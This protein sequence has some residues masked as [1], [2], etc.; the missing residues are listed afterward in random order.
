MA[1][2]FNLRTLATNFG[3]PIG[4]RA[5][6][7]GAEKAAE[8]REEY[9]T[10]NKRNNIPIQVIEDVD[11]YDKLSLFGTPLYST[12]FI[13]KPVYSDYE[14]NE[15]SQEYVKKDV[16]LLHNQESGG[17]QGCFIESVLI[18]VSQQR[19]IVKTIIN[20]R[21]GSVKEFINNGDYSL[22][23]QGFFATQN[24][25]VYPEE[26]VKVLVSYLEAPV[27]LKITNSFL[28]NYF[29]IN[30]MVVEELKFEQVV[31]QRNIQFFTINA[32]SD[33]PFEVI[34]INPN[35]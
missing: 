27:S 9:K 31:G 35:N 2:D 16:E 5:I 29:N 11:D 33:R 13:E 3:V 30:Q 7:V 23:I 17:V 10:A 24:P 22:K 15:T 19:N 14:F 34:E 20:G 6:M 1:V 26:D 21:N 25:D 18:E 28:N 4:K 32:S 12:F 8:V